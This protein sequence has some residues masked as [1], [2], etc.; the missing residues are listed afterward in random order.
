MWSN[1]LH[2]TFRPAVL[3][4]VP[5]IKVANTH[6]STMRHWWLRRG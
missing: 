5:R 2:S 1:V 3:I 4:P 6:F